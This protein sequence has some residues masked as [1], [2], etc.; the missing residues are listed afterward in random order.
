MALSKKVITAISA[1]TLLAVLSGAILDGLLFREPTTVSHTVSTQGASPPP[2]AARLLDQSQPPPPVQVAPT[3]EKNETGDQAKPGELKSAQLALREIMR[4]KLVVDTEHGIRKALDAPVAANLTP[5]AAAIEE[6]KMDQ[7]QDKLT[8]LAPQREACADAIDQGLDK[9]VYD[10]LLAAARLGDK[11]A[12][13]CYIVAPFEAPSLQNDGDALEEYKRNATDLLNKGIA[14]GDWVMVDLLEAGSSTHRGRAG[15]FNNLLIHDDLTSYQ[16]GRLLRLGAVEEFAEEMDQQLRRSIKRLEEQDGIT[17]AEILAADQWAQ[18]MYR[19]Y[20][21][22]SEPLTGRPAPCVN[23]YREEEVP[24][25][26][27]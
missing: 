21:A 2:P 16:Y 10:A 6:Q 15:W 5:S 4:C 7:L 22:A 13:T 25:P 8:A 24:E 12:A 11:D 9:D 23:P 19:R 18:Q 27:K 1:C 14:A 26:V 20:F 3:L 17:H